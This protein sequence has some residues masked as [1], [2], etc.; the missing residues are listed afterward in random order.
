MPTDYER[1][2]RVQ[3][4]LDDALAF[5]RRN[6][7]TPFVRPKDPAVVPD[8]EEMV[9]MRPMSKLMKKGWDAVVQAYELV[10]KMKPNEK[11]ALV[12]ES[13]EAALAFFKEQAAAFHLFL[14]TAHRDDKPIDFHVFS[15]GDGTLYSGS[16]DEIKD[17]LLED[18]NTNGLSLFNHMMPSSPNPASEM[19]EHVNKHRASAAEDNAHHLKPSPKPKAS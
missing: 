19:R 7:P 14:A 18:K 9:L 5:A 17:K 12:F 10:F 8:E 13:R 1:K 15:C 16:Y 3:K 2:K 4:E 6:Q 11:G